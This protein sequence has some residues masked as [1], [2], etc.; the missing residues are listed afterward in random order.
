MTFYEKSA[1]SREATY[2]EFPVRRKDGSEIWVGQHVRPIIT[3]NRIEG[4]QG[5]ARD[6]TDRVSAQADL[7][8]ERDFVSAILDT[9]P[10]LIM[11][12]D[13]D[14]PNVVQFN[15]ACEELS[16]VSMTEVADRPIWS[17][18]SC[19]TK[20]AQRFGKAFRD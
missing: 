12:L 16:G 10:S 2:L 17:C 13:S 19:S 15:R 14:R 7:R 9:A 20:I 5:M 6:I 4:F 3:Q 8:A 18:R 11:V 1:K